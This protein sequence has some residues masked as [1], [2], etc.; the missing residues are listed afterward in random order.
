MLHGGELFGDS[1]A[2]PRIEAPKYLLKQ[3]LIL[4][5]L[6]WGE[7]KEELLRIALKYLALD[8]ASTH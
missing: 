6:R 1:R 7:D 2:A 8:V 4:I 3:T 5:C